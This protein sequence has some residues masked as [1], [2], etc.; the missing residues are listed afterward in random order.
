MMKKSFLLA[1]L[2]ATNIF[3]ANIDFEMAQKDPQSVITSYSIHYTKLYESWKVFIKPFAL[4]SICFIIQEAFSSSFKY[5]A[6]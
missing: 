6:R 1:A 5:L 4:K 3:A 2:I